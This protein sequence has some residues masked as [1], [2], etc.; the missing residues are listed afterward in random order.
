MYLEKNI[1]I[2]VILL[3][4]RDIVLINVLIWPNNFNIRKYVGMSLKLESKMLFKKVLDGH[5]CN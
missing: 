2:S 3:H 4:A 5:H 1:L